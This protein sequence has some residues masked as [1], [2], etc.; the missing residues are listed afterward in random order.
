MSQT[1]HLLVSKGIQ[2]L[3]VQSLLSEYSN[4]AILEAAQQ[5]IDEG[6]NQFVLD[7]TGMPYTNSVGLNFIISLQARCQEQGGDMVVA[8]ASTKIM[9][10]LEITKLHD[11]FHLSNSV[12]DAFQ[13]LQLL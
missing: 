6:F 3:R 2:V 7:L 9:Q 10:L 11:I 5:K 13:Q 8:N 12:E 1:Y 4:R